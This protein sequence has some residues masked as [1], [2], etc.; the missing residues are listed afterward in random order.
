MAPIRYNT[1]MGKKLLSR[2][3]GVKLVGPFGIN[4]LLRICTLGEGWTKHRRYLS[5][6]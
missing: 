5:V 2:K 6:E 3:L 4:K 1:A